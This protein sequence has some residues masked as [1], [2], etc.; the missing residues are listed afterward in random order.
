MSFRLEEIDQIQPFWRWISYW[1]RNAVE[2]NSSIDWTHSVKRNWPREIS[3]N[4]QNRSGQGKLI[5]VIVW[6]IE[7]KRE[8][9]PTFRVILR[10][11]NDWTDHL[12]WFKL[13]I[14][15]KSAQN[16]QGRRCRSFREAKYDFMFIQT[17]WYYF[18]ERKTV[19]RKCRV[20]SPKPLRGRSIEKSDYCHRSKVFQKERFN[21]MNGIQK[22]NL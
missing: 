13:V 8:S 20:S 9:I 17:R 12:H 14:R 2:I 19:S 3:F 21:Q 15:G 7:D 4:I 18:E 10:W 5:G 22:D 16:R 11:E 1:I 6:L